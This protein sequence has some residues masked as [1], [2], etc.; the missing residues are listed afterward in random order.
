LDETTQVEA[1]PLGKNQ[2]YH[3]C[4][5]SMYG[6]RVVSALPVWSKKADA[7][8]VACGKKF[9]RWQHILAA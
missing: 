4:L 2:A 5:M 9:D 1:F 3:I 7:H 8:G 6:R